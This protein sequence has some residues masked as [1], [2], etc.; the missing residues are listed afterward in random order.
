MHGWIAGMLEGLRF[1]KAERCGS[2]WLVPL[3]RPGEGGEG[4]GHGKGPGY[5]PM[6]EAMARGELLVTEVPPAG[7]VS[8]VHVQ[9]RGELP[10]LMLEGEEWSGGKQN[11]VMTTSVMLASGADARVAVACSEPGRWHYHGAGTGPALGDSGAV[12]PIGLR[13][14]M[15]LA[16]GVGAAG[17]PDQDAIQAAAWRGLEGWRARMGT[18]RTLAEWQAQEASRWDAAEQRVAWVPGQVGWLVAVDGEWV[19]LEVV[20]RPAAWRRWHGKMLRGVLAP[21]PWAGPSKVGGGGTGS[22]QNSAGMGSRGGPKGWVHPGN[23]KPDSWRGLDAMAADEVGSEEWGRR[24]RAVM[25]DLARVPGTASRATGEGQMEEHVSS[26]W[27]GA[28]LMQAGEVLHGGWQRV[29]VAAAL[30]R[31]EAREPVQEPAGMVSALR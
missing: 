30:D 7:E 21:W 18:G 6:P 2:V 19:A 15:R 14:E 10:V 5:R 22:C 8:R 16:R 23:G 24:A 3:G 4:Q 1:G 25:H 11:R 9:N 28:A 27:V 31:V 17:E 12:A 29:D 26:H 13:R 20:S